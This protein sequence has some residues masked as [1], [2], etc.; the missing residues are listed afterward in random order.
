VLSKYPEANSIIEDVN[1]YTFASV[2]HNVDATQ[3]QNHFDSTTLFDDIIFNF[4][5][6]GIEDLKR[7]RSFLSHILFRFVNTSIHNVHIIFAYLCFSAK[8]RLKSNGFITIALA[9][10]QGHGW[11][12]Y[13]FSGIIVISC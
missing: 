2:L 3:L 1:K 10:T 4:P 8:K 12:M 11:E 9:E 6:L 5:H 7:H 13:V